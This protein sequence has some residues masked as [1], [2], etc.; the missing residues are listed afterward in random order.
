MIKNRSVLFGTPKSKLFSDADESL[1]E[2]LKDFP[3]AL[4]AY[5]LI[6]ADEEARSHWDMANFITVRKLGY[7]DHGRVHGLLTGA[8]SVAILELLLAAGVKPD[9][10]EGGFGDVDD[11]YMVVLLS[12]MLHDIGNQVHRKEHEQF[13]VTLA[14]PVLNRILEKLIPSAEKRIKLRALMLHSIYTHDLI[15]DPLTIEA[16]I[17][18][19]ADG[20]DITK[21]RG[22]KAFSLGSIDIHSVSALAVDEVRIVKGDRK[23]VEI[24]VVMNNPAGLFQVEEIL[25]RKVVKSPIRGYISVVAEIVEST[26]PREGDIKIVRLH[27]SEPRFVLV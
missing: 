3:K 12:T 9:T 20:T 7:N 2:D 23:P 14:I 15:A 6:L 25:T 8:A 11:C 24:Q 19:V 21:G 13:G 16:G 27:D 4:A 1:R 10:L 17:T 22:R 18:A 5:E 26:E